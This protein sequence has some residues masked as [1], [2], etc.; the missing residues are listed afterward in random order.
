MRPATDSRFSKGGGIRRIHDDLSRWASCA[1]HSDVSFENAPSDY[2]MLK[3]NVL[4]KNGGGDTL[5]T[6]TYDVLDRI[7]PSFRQYLETLTAEHNAEFFHKEA[8][9]LG[10]T[11]RDDI[12]RG[13]PINKGST[14]IAHHPVIRTNPV[15]G[16]KA[17]FVNRGFTGRI[18]DVSKDESDM[19]LN[20]LNQ[21][22]VHNIDM[23]CRFRWEKGSV[24]LW[25]NRCSWH[26]AT[27]DYD[28]ERSGDRASSIG[29]R[30]YFDPKSVLKSEGLR[31]EGKRW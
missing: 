25:D 5:W 27:F 8:A 14:L 16:W 31:A 7:S 20:Y 29:E 26:S 10:I 6:S 22:C 24:A 23:Q 18:D 3:I 12:E 19:I 9:N 2:S 21:V 4:P 30:P 17:L 15:T 13:N 1:Y 28:E 11:V